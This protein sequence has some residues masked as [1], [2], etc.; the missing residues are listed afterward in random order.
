VTGRDPRGDLSQVPRAGKI[1]TVLMTWRRLLVIV[2]FDALAGAALS[3]LYGMPPARAA[4]W[5]GLGGLVMMLFLLAVD[6]IRKA[7]R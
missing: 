6:G 5:S 3:P 4:F 1:L 2:G 7:K